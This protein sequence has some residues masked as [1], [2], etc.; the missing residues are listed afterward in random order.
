MLE[1]WVHRNSIIVIGIII[2]HHRFLR[3]ANIASGHKRTFVPRTRDHPGS[4][5]SSSFPRSQLPESPENIKTFKTHTHRRAHTS[6]GVHSLPHH[7][8][9]SQRVVPSRGPSCVVPVPQVLQ[10][11][12]SFVQH[13]DTLCVF[14]PQLLQ[15]LC[16]S[17][18]GYFIFTF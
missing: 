2:V 16:S 17:Q 1:N 11:L 6:R 14:L 15:L 4:T 3:R 5:P 8:V 18:H 10:L 9:Q 13:L 12:L 7:G